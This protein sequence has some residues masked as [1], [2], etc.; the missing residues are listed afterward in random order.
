MDKIF[1]NMLFWIYFSG[2]IKHFILPSVN[3]EYPL[4]RILQ[5]W[6]TVTW[7]NRDSEPCAVMP[8]RTHQLGTRS[9]HD[10]S[11]RRK[12][13]EAPYR[14]RPRTIRVISS[15]SLGSCILACQTFAIFA[16][17]KLR[18]W[19]SPLSAPVCHTHPIQP[20]FSDVCNSIAQKKESTH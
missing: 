14:L 18:G 16:K 11:S 6:F 13:E 20:G 19:K 9:P 2:W 10:A 8:S 17:L 1:V 5:G 12:R 3:F 15:F 4:F 7:T